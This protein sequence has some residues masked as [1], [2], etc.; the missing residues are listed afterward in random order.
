MHGHASHSIVAIAGLV[1]AF[2][3]LI[4]QILSFRRGN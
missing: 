4:L 3:A 1:V 2:A